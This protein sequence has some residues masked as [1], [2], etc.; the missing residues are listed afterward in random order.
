MLVPTTPEA[1]MARKTQWHPVFAELL[2]PLVESHYRL[3]TNVPVGDTPREAD[4]V[5]LRRTRAGRLPA[6]GLWR[7]LKTWNVLEFK[8]PTVSPRQNDLDLL[9][10]L[11]LGIH[12]RLNDQRVRERRPKLQPEATALWY[13]ANRLGRRLLQ[14]W[15]RRIPGLGEQS[16]GLWHGAIVGYL[17]YFVSTRDLP[18]EEASLP[19]HLIAQEPSE[20]EQAVARMLAESAV[21]WERYGG[22]L[23]SLHPV[24]YQEVQSMAKQSKTP[25]R[26]D[27]NPII[28]SMG[29]KW[30]IDQLGAKRVIDELGSKQVINEL[31][32]KRVIGDLGAKQVLDELVE[33]EQVWENL[34]PEQ[35]RK[36]K[37]RLQE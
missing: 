15:R 33:M 28:E 5:L 36:L 19:L 37:R 2:R 8:G 21:L 14:D 31:G 10:E 27:L 16:P 7:Q 20:T 23:A 13:L 18:V 12:R 22:W 30:V 25:L 26:I 34:T 11:G 9:L 29:M 1:A 6:A 17:I 4:F 35:R 32:A 3:E 24:V